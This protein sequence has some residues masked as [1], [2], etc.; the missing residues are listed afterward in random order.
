MQGL[1]PLIFKGLMGLK[2]GNFI[3]LL[4]SV[5]TLSTLTT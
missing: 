1:L 4:Q 2:T 5:L 3:D